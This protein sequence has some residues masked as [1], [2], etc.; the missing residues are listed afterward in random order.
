MYKSLP[1]KTKQIFFVLTKLAIIVG[2]FYFIYQKIGQNDQISFSTFL[3]QLR[4][5]IFQNPINLLILVGLSSLNWFFESIKWQKLSSFL[6]KNDL[7]NAF[8]QATASL[9]VSLFTP[10][11]IGEYGAKALY[12]RKGFR[13]KIMLLNL[14]GNSQQLLITL[15]IGAMGLYSLFTHYEIAIEYYALKRL[16]YIVLI[17]LLTTLFTTQLK[18]RKYQGFYIDRIVKFTRA[19]PKK[20]LIQTLVLSLVRYLVFSFQYYYLLHIS[21][22]EITYFTAMMFISSMYLV[23]S[24]VPSFSFFDWVIKGS[25]AV[26]VFGFY[27]V[28]ELL[29]ISIS[30]L[31]WILNFA[32][33]AA[34][35]S[36]YVLSFNLPKAYPSNIGKI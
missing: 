31:M 24:L 25:V 7:F 23:A 30:L 15:L 28:D 18:R 13:R 3:G 27:P 35:G 12:Y 34:I 17:L 36:Y 6:K 1:H 29:I 10:N 9:T 20:V 5:T 21:G 32:F 2:A 14:I 16:S 22:V 26:W 19:F 33:P 8:K 4:D 11:R